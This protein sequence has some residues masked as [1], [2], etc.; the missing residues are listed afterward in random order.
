MSA[1]PQIAFLGTGLMGAPM[2]RNL[3]AKGFTITA[4]NRTREKAEALVPLGA[5]VSASASD[6]VA[7]ADVVITMLE[8]GSI[9]EAV[10]FESGAAEAMRPGAILVD[11]SSIKPAEAQDH[12]LRL[13]WRGVKHLDAPVSGGTVGAEAATLAIMAAGKEADFETVKPALSALGRPVHVGPS[14]A[15]QLAKLANQIIVGVTIGAVAEA[16]M[17][18]KRG[19]ADPAKVRDALRGGFAESRIL[20]DRIDDPDLAIDASSVMVLKHCGPR[21]YPGMAEVGNMP[22]PKKLLKQGVRDMIRISDARMSGTAYGTVILHVAPEASAGGPLA[23]VQTGD[24]IE[25]DVDARKLHLAVDQAELD[26]RRAAWTP[27]APMAGRGYT[28]L[29]IDHVLQADQ[30]ADLDF[31]VDRSGS[32]VPR[33]NH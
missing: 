11:M 28:K 33:D 21:G 6:A 10:I 18:A 17:F 23:L 1:Q 12:A 2:A 5:K 16:L 14:G 29:Y 31:L 32:P 19:G 20:H 9:R 7:G 22:L 3:L 15:G 26:R 4:W 27:P 13:A 30:G 24:I 8:N 25:V